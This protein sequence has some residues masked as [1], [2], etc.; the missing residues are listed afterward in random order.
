MDALG[1]GGCDE[2]GFQPFGLGAGLTQGV[3]L[4]WDE[5]RALGARVG[6]SGVCEQPLAK[7]VSSRQRGWRTAVSGVGE[8]PLAQMG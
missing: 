6:D 5:R 1:R 3:A 7:F 8:R 4:G 2:A